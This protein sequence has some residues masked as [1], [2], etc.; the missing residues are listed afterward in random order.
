MLKNKNIKRLY[1]KIPGYIKNLLRVKNKIYDIKIRTKY[2]FIGI[3]N[4][5]II[6]NITYYIVLGNK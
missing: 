1:K 4:F 2:K 5:I 3:S 6:N